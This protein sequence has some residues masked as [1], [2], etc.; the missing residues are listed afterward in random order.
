MK[1]ALISIGLLCL[2]QAGEDLRATDVV[3]N[4]LTA[5][6]LKIS[7]DM[8]YQSP[9]EYRMELYS[10]GDARVFAV[11]RSLPDE[12]WP[13]IILVGGQVM[14]VKGMDLE[15]GYEIDALDGPVLMMQLALS[16]LS[17]A[18]PEGPEGLA[19]Q[20]PRK[21]EHL[22]QESPIGV[23]TT[24]AAGEFST[25][26]RVSGSVQRSDGEQI[27]Y[28]LDFSYESES[29]PVGI[30]LSGRWERTGPLPDLD[31][32]LALEG[33]KPYVIGP[34]H[35]STPSSS[36]YDFGAQPMDTVFDTVGEVQVEVRQL[37]DD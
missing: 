3:W 20:Q 28:A 24:S 13:Q 29:G 16:L 18:V 31:P 12:Q 33:W 7:G 9:V 5:L 21:L 19:D 30:Q 34:I 23:G 32:E 10:A 2:I 22:E 14:L 6:Q 26:W 37:P 36:I 8:A 35:R 1:R 15:E 4:D 27:A 11:D 25:P 17:T